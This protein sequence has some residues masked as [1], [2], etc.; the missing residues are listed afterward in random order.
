M[1]ETLKMIMVLGTICAI[2]GFSLSFLKETTA[3][4]I[5]EQ[6]LINVQGPAVHQVYPAADN[7]PLAERKEFP[8]PDGR[9]VTVFPYKKDGALVGVAMENTGPGYGGDIG[10]LVGFDLA[11]DTLLGIGI[12]ASKETPGIGSA[13]AEPRFGKQ[14][15][16]KPLAVGL[17][18][19]GGNIDAI[20]GATI[21]STGTVI[22]VQHAAA[23]YKTL[24]SALTSAW[25]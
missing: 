15:A 13:V 25:K 20:S 17:T 3:P 10:V 23:D 2:S 9:T 11:R 19:K 21:S 16:G 12:T 1:R 4:I 18:S 8:L 24:K 7:D 14:F 6:I 22:A 5:A